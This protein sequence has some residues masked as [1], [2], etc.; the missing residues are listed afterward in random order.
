MN[1]SAWRR[2][3]REMASVLSGQM[4]PDSLSRRW[5]VCVFEQ[6]VGEKCFRGAR[7][8]QDGATVQLQLEPSEQP[9]FEHDSLPSTMRTN[10]SADR[11][12]SVQYFHDSPIWAPSQQERRRKDAVAILPD[13]LALTYR[14][15]Q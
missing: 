13:A 10:L 8:N 7:R 5:E 6:E 9:G 2:F 11:A 14:C 12:K 3:R 15:D 1:Q 4:R